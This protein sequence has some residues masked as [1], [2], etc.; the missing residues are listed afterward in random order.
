MGVEGAEVVRTRREGEATGA[1]RL[2]VLP[3]MRIPRGLGVE[4]VRLTLFGVVGAGSSILSVGSSVGVVGVV[5]VAGVTSGMAKTDTGGGV[6]G[7]ASFG[8]SFRLV[9]RLAYVLGIG[10]LTRKG[11][12]MGMGDGIVCLNE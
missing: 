2:W 8:A 7:P 9:F 10:L 1:P 3:S 6:D 12:E 5:G 11:G 4:S